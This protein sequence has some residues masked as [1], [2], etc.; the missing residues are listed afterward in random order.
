VTIGYS[1]ADPSCPPWIEHQGKRV[2]LRLLDPKKNAQRK[3]PLRP[4]GSP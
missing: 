1:L 2:A 3:R 4:E